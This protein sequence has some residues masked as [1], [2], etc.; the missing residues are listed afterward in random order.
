MDLIYRPLDTA[1]LKIARKKGINTVSGVDMFLAQGFAQWE[2]WTGKSAPEAA[3][4]RAVLQSLRAE[5]APRGK[6]RGSRA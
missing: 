2:L 4:R 1:L 3:M 6:S 5:E